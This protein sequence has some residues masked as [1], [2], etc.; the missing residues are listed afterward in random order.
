MKCLN[1]EFENGVTLDD[2]L[3]E[4]ALQ[5]IFR[6]VSKHGL[7]V[8]A[9]GILKGEKVVIV[10]ELLPD[11]VPLSTWFDKE[12]VAKI[13]A[14]NNKNQLLNAID[15]VAQDLFAS[16]IVHRDLSHANF[17]VQFDPFGNF[18][19]L[20]LID[21]GRAVWSGQ[22]VLLTKQEGCIN[23]K[24][25]PPELRKAITSVI[26]SR[27]PIPFVFTEAV[28]LWMIGIVMYEIL[29]GKMREVE[30]G[31]KPYVDKKEQKKML[32]SLNSMSTLDTTVGT[33]SHIE[34]HMTSTKSLLSTH[35]ANRTSYLQ[36]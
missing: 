3:K 25:F 8:Y 6:D 9:C 2:I 24:Q 14:E 33:S 11:C 21:F 30:C 28:D 34:R 27:K 17:L 10:M 15:A 7:D 23:N 16:K 1:L 35:P 12:H 31:Q 32:S 36:I 26:E 18:Q 4:A 29:D 13:Q 22:K 19:K 20:Y 5:N